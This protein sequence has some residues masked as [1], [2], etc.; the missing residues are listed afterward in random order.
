M[1]PG[2]YSTPDGRGLV[3]RPLIDD[4]PAPTLI[5]ADMYGNHKPAF[6]RSIIDIV[7]DLFRDIDSDDTSVAI[8]E[9]AR[10]LSDVD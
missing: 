9:V 7:K 4:L 2:K 10:T 5:V 1:M 3:R 6:V 8:P